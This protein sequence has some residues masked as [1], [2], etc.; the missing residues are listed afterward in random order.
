MPVIGAVVVLVDTKLILPAPVAVNP[1][2]VLLFV[3]LYTVPATGPVKL[4]VTVLP[5]HTVWLATGVTDGVGFTVMVNVF[6]V[7]VQVTPP[8]LYTGVT[9]IVA[10]CKILVVLVAVKL[11]ILPVPVAA[12][13]TVVLVL[14]QLKTVPATVPVKFTGAVGEPLHNTWLPGCPTVG[15]GFTVI[16]KVI[17]GPVQVTPPLV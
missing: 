10:V 6:G 3:Q 4:A 15:V 12:N 11:A 7:P 16:V 9:V 14:V 17:D 1:I 8:L 2:A 5:A 13:P